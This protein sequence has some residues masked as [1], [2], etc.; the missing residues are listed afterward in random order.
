MS[1]PVIQMANGLKNFSQI[2][3]PL[4]SQAY[5]DMLEEIK[6]NSILW[7]IDRRRPNSN[8]K[9][10]STACITLRHAVEGKYVDFETAD[11]MLDTVDTEF[12]TPFPKTMGHLKRIAEELNA[13][14]GRVYFERIIKSSVIYPYKH[15]GS[16]YDK[17]HRFFIVMESPLGTTMR[18][19]NEEVIMM[20][21]EL[22]WANTKERH[23]MDNPSTDVHVSH[24]IFDLQLTPAKQ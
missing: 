4:L 10:M 14:L 23:D 3:L 19:G 24:L 11:D 22:W 9:L 13:K 17:H 1:Q 5:A 2:Q 6:Y 7:D 18:S 15:F 12:V 20:P 21:G 16:Y 8:R